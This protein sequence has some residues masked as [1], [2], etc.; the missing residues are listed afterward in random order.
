[1]PPNWHKKT[2]RESMYIHHL[3][4]GNGCICVYIYHIETLEKKPLYIHIYISKHQIVHFIYLYFLKDYL[5]ERE[6]AHL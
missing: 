3:D 4:C 5:F 1:M 2:S 6:R